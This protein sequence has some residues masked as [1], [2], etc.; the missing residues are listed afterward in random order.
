MLKD[1]MRSPKYMLR[2]ILPFLLIAPAASA[3]MGFP[4]IDAEDPLTREQVQAA[5]S[6]QTHRGT[7]QFRQKHI[8][9]F[10]FTET[11]FADG[12]VRHVQKSSKQGERVDTG[13]WEMEGERI[14][15]DYDTPGL[16]RACFKI[17]QRGNCFYHYQV[18]VQG[19][20]VR[21]F[22]ARTY[23]KGETPNC[24]PSLA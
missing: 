21:G 17:Y 22:T 6:G 7:Y 8:D 10:A 14:C 9:S 18:S 23:I 15:F 20:R 19:Q 11:T 24:E 1:G 4:D 16:R 13:N 12:R 3:D 5:F 2:Y